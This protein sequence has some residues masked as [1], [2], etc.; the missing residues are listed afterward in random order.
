MC[1]QSLLP[2]QV[3]AQV[4]VLGEAC[5]AVAAGERPLAAVDAQVGAQS[6][7][8]GQDLSADGT[9]VMLLLRR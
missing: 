6:L 2:A 1:I 4:A 3:S 9:D 5:L 7:R 8:L